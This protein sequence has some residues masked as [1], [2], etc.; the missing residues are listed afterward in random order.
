MDKSRDIGFSAE[1]RAAVY[2]EKKGYQIL[3]RNYT[4]PLGEIDI[5]ARDRGDIVF[6]EVKYRKGAVPPSLEVITTEK[7]KKIVKAA[8]SYIRTH[9]KRWPS[10]TTFRF[11]AIGLSDETL[12]HIEGAFDEP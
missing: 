10:K 9:G 11:D 4:T 12:V 7:Q 8:Y 5:V 2:L 6:C 1:Q 3:A